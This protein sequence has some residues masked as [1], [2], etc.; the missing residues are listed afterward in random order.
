MDELCLDHQFGERLGVCFANFMLGNHLIG[1]IDSRH[2]THWHTMFRSALIYWAIEI[3]N[4]RLGSSFQQKY[5]FSIQNRSSFV[6]FYCADF[7]LSLDLFSD[8]IFL[9]RQIRRQQKRWVWLVVY[10]SCVRFIRYVS[11]KKGEIF[12]ILWRKIKEY[13]LESS[14]Y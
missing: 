8:F 14:F 3:I 1:P 11:K 12:K 6:F 7:K 4:N 2:R 10:I 9:E 5:S 13:I